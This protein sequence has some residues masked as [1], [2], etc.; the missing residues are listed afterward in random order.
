MIPL[1]LIRG[2]GKAGGTGIK[3]LKK[4]GGVGT[5]MGSIGAYSDY[6]E[7]RDNGESIPASLLKAGGSALLYSVPYIGAALMAKD[8]IEAG[9]GFMQDSLQEMRQ[10][11]A[12]G[13]IPFRNAFFQDNKNFATMRQ[14]G[15][16]QAKKSEYTLQQSMMGNEAQYLHRE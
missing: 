14:A 10:E 12:N 15:M 16:A 13:Q 1:T 9:A 11:S 4:I 8:T 5:I 6:N 3:G 7:A 2:I